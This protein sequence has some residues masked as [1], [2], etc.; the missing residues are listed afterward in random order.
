MRSILHACLP[1]KCPRAKRTGAT[2][3]IGG[4]QNAQ[5]FIC[6]PSDEMPASKANG[7]YSKKEETR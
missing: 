5:H 1:T 2:L 3:K 4:R 6:M 7:R